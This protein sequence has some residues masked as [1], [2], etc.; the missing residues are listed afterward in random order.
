MGLECSRKRGSTGLELANKILARVF[1]GIIKG[2]GGHKNSACYEEE[3]HD[4][5]SCWACQCEYG[6]SDI[7]TSD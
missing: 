5:E 1:L 2:M 6:T 7:P 3:G 4:C